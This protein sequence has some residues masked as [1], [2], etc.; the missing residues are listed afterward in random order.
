MQKQPVVLSG[1]WE[2]SNYAKKMLRA[3]ARKKNIL[4]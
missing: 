2:A 4:F 1:L 3:K